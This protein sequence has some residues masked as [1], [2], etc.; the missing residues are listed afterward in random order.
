MRPD[1][2]RETTP[3]G[4]G[5]AEGFRGALDQNST[6]GVYTEPAAS[7]TTR[8]RCLEALG[9]AAL[10]YAELGW[11]MF[12]LGV[13]SKLPKIPKSA[14]GRGFHDATV[15]VEMITS[16]WSRWLRAN[17][18]VRTGPTSNL[19]VLDVDPRHGGDESFDAL[20]AK[21]GPLPDTLVAA[22]PSGGTHYYFS[23]PDVEIRND[24]GRL[25][26]AGLDVRGE[27]GYV[28]VAPS[29]VNGRPYHWLAGSIDNLAPMPNWMIGLLEHRRDPLPCTAPSRRRVSDT[30]AYGRRALES[31]VGKVA[32]A[33]EG[34]RNDQLNRSAHALGQLAGGGL[35]GVSEACDALLIAAVR[36]GLSETEAEATITSGFAAGQRQPRR[37]P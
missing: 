26:G 36:T 13:G 27:G 15:D 21:H 37:R 18:G 5:V 10:D 32:M 34:Q 35:L 1:P 17:V 29:V 31:E 33:A 24:A 6:A 12:P 8:T 11:P 23:Y 4:A 30:G 7:I 25:L 2:S 14:G 20:E 16:W 19:V 28:A 9:L 3:A 22:T